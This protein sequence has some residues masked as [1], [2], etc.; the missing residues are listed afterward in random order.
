MNHPAAPKKGA[1]GEL[2]GYR[3]VG[4]DP[5]AAMV[6]PTLGIAAQGSAPTIAQGNRN[7]F[8]APPKV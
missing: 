6:F 4:A 5:W 3:A 8:A 1:I 7:H 2:T